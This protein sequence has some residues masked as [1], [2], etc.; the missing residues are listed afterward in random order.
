[1]YTEVKTK[2][3]IS[4]TSNGQ[5]W[6]SASTGTLNA[7]LGLNSFPNCLASSLRL[8]TRSEHAHLSSLA[9][10]GITSKRGKP[11]VGCP[12]AP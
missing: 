8:R 11:L 9:P 10:L 2:W 4:E 7:A 6:N 1:M 5:F 12:L 3:S